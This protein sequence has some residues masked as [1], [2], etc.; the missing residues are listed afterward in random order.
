MRRV[1]AC[2]VVLLAASPASAQTG[3]E[4]E[5]G[6]DAGG[7]ARLRVG[8]AGS[9]PFV[10]QE[11]ASVTGLSADVWAAVAEASGYQYELVAVP[12]VKEALQK[13]E[14]GELDVAIGPISITAERAKRVRF[15]QPYFQSSLG[16]LASTES[17][18]VMAA[19]APFL[20]QAFLFGVVTLL[21]V[22]TGV[23]AILWVLERKANP[24]EFSASPVGGV[25][26]G[27]WLALVTMTTVGYGD[28]APKTLGGRVVTGVW[29]IISML[30]VSSL[31]AGIATALTLASLEEGAISSAA[32]L[33]KRRVAALPGTT[34]ARFVEA[35]RGRVV[36]SKTVDEA[37]QRVDSQQAA[38]IV[39][40]RPMLQY[41]L[42]KHPE[43]SLRLAEAEYEPQ[44]YGFAVGR[45]RSDLS[46]RLSVGLLELAERDRVQKITATWLGAR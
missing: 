39:H 2:L 41:Y 36:A 32:G 31:T 11:G 7:P 29:M 25:L 13:V 37:A 3:A 34:G 21:L 45:A 6:A 1:H 4:T 16:I 40:D 18:G 12:T 42:A 14:A 26:D 33:A 5:A 23:G 9:A 20:S 8:A 10:V 35:R 22:L 30:T 17:A 24:D 27:L 46:Y 44:G 19:L 43:S 38:A 15:T 28:K